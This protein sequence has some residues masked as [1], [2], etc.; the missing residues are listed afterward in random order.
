MET[1]GT[2]DRA[3]GDRRARSRKS[4]ETLDDV[5]PQEPQISGFAAEGATNPMVV[6]VPRRVKAERILDRYGSRPASD[7]ACL[8]AEHGIPLPSRQLASHSLAGPVADLI[9]MWPRYGD[10]DA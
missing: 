9:E 7:D 4:A 2:C 6:T 3:R 1:V 5:T 8:H 10:Q